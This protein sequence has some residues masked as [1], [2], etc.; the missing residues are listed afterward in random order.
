[1]STDD[2]DDTVRVG[3][4]DGV[5]TITIDRPDA[6]NAM[7]LAMRER[8]VDLFTSA[9]DDGQVVQWLAALAEPPRRMDR[10]GLTLSTNHFLRA[11][12][13]EV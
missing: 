5:R 8:I 1:M 12:V 6:R 7:S 2:V 11:T 3:D 9:N 13:R 4:L 10:P